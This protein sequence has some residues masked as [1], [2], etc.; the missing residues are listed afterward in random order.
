LVSFREPTTDPKLRAQ[1]ERVHAAWNDALAARDAD[2]LYAEDA[3][4]ESP[5]VSY[6][7]RTER[8]ICNGRA[9]IRDFIPLVFRHQPDER[10][11]HRNPVF[12]DGHTMMWE[13]PRE[14]PDG[15]QMD[16][17]EVMELKDGLIQRHRVYWGWY[18]VRTLTSGSHRR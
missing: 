10:R 5:L 13:Y 16:F 4:I 18:G 6:L 17:T 11:T 3:T 14:T 12:T 9:A 7:P 2:A 15:D 8:G 1:A